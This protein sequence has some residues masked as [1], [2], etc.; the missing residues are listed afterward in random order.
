MIKTIKCNKCDVEMG[1]INKPE[2]T[3]EDELN[4]RQSVTC[5]NGHTECVLAVTEE[6]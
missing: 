5:P 1:T 3:A 4:Y 2:I 6:E